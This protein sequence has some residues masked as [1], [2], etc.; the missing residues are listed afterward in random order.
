MVDSGLSYEQ[1]QYLRNLEASFGKDKALEMRQIFE[2]NKQPKKHQEPEE[3]QPLDEWTKETSERL[4]KVV[5]KEWKENRIAEEKI[6]NQQMK[7]LQHQ[8]KQTIQHIE[9]SYTG[10]KTEL[11]TEMNGAIKA[12]IAELNGQKVRLNL[13]FHEQIQS[14]LNNFLKPIQDA[15]VALST[16]QTEIVTLSFMVDK[17]NKIKLV[18]RYA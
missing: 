12:R 9:E 4:K 2:T 3:S 6:L 10:F 7:E 14:N 11:E 1:E 18:V 15:C 13:A 5:A 16:R 8:T 17:N